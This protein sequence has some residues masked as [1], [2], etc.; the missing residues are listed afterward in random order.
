MFCPRC[1]RRY[2]RDHRFCPYDGDALVDGPRMDLLP[3]R[4][5]RFAGARL[6][7]RYDVRGFIGKGAM[8]RVYLAE[9]TRTHQPVAVK[10]LSLAQPQHGSAHA[11]ERFFR[12]AR[13]AASIGHPNI[14]KILDVGER[15]D[16]SPYIVMEFL[17]G[18][19][20]GELLRRDALLDADIALPILRQAAAGLGAAHA[21]GVI[22]RDV[23][24]DNIFLVGEPGD[25]YAVK[26]LDF[27]LA[28]LE[29]Q[30]GV[31]AAGT[32]VGTLEYMAPEQVVSDAPD[33]R[34]DVY[35]LGVVMYRM[36]TGVLPFRAKDDADLLG[37][38][39]LR[40]PPPPTRG[41]QGFDAGVEAVML[42]ALRKRPS[43]R[44]ASMA[45]F[46]EDLERL[47]GDRPGPLAALE[48]PSEPDAYE[49]VGVVARNALAFFR[50]R[51]DAKP[52]R[53]KRARK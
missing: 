11:Y 4:A 43:N 6:G 41:T 52:P 28:K 22:H 44:Y 33:A 46:L 9:D 19:S 5:T 29:A 20:L 53:S 16:G 34:T 3:S 10:I 12:E 13:A 35:G 39:L 26:I 36:F 42:R 37:E 23:K 40:A 32:A 14:V 17:F 45:A 49:P 27:G 25:P 7:D 50:A 15:E 18:E 47:A 21:V 38:Q 51:L 2:D 48:P 31:T 1:H 8:A 30:T 24:P